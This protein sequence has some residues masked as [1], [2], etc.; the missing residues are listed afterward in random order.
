VYRHS[1]V[2][3]SLQCLLPENS[4]NKKLGTNYEIKI[5]SGYAFT[6]IQFIS[7]AVIMTNFQNTKEQIHE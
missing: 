3:T 6:N 5:Y 7:K 1:T 2:S 4:K